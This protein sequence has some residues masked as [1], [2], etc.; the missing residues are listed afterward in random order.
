MR[1]DLLEL[2][3]DGFYAL[4]LMRRG[5]MPTDARA[6]VEAIRNFLAELDTSAAKAGIASEDT[7]AA[8]YAYCALVD[9][10][11]LGA[12][13]PFRAEWERNPLQLVLFGDH[14]AGEN[15]F[16]Q[17]EALRVAGALRLQ[18]LKVYYFCLLMGFQGRY[19]IEGTEKLH[20]L[21]ARLGDEIAFLRGK[22]TSFAPHWAP[23]DHVAHAL[24][25]IVPPWVAAAALLGVC[26]IGF[27]SFRYA[28]Q[29]E[30]RHRLAAYQ[31]V[32]QP[33][34]RMANITITLP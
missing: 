29:V 4:L 15:F 11:V 22:R 5:Q 18:A 10:T 8:K 33:P 7:H 19:R 21:T 2:M 16:S 12:R 32:I 6:F 9:E 17:L 24:R 27:L 14:L 30:A 20:Y 31:S 26:V 23:P 25:R 28:L 34:V 3:S 13:C 1:R